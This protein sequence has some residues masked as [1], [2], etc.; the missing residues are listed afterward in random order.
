[1]KKIT[2]SLDPASIENAIREIKAYREWCDRKIS[3]LMVALG[4]DGK[5]AS[6]YGSMVSVVPTENGCKILAQ[7]DQIAFIEFGAGASA[8]GYPKRVPGVV[9]DMGSWSDSELGTGAYAAT[10]YE[11]WY[12]G[13]VRYTEVIQQRGMI[14][15]EESIMAHVRQIA[16]RVFANG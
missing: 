10:N 9:T 2:L 1:M 4:E 16:E 14:H 5:L 3:E 13:G 6:G 15:A 7:G 8:Y 12:F 11:Y